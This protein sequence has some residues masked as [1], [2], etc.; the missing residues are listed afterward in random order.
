MS[1]VILGVNSNQWPIKQNYYNAGIK[2][3]TY[4]KNKK[5]EPK[6]THINNS[7]KS[8]GNNI[9]SDFKIKKTLKQNKSL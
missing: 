3:Y 6:S 7:K 2:T 1:V 4:V 5:Q 9:S 8:S